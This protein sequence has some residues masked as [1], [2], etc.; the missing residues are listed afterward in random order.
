M[1]LVLCGSVKDCY[2]HHN[3]GRT[4]TRRYT[5]YKKYNYPPVQLSILI[6]TENPHERSFFS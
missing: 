2:S 3:M 5:M 1:D 6:V 4:F